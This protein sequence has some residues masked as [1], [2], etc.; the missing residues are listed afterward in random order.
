MAFYLDSSALTKLVR[1]EEETEALQDWL[2]GRS[3]RL[4]S[5]DL[6]RTELLRAAARRDAD[7]V[8]QARALLDRIHLEP[9]TTRLAEESGL[10]LSGPL[11][12]LDAIHIATAL[13][14]GDDLEGFVTYDHRQAAAA[15]SLGLP[16][17]APGQAQE[18]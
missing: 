4:V 5:S 14:S 11:R 18:P 16:V 3:D 17:L 12:T 9:V 15:R 7:H 2:D 13:G 10:L 1:T 6:A 8:S